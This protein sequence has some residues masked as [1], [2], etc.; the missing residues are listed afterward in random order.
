MDSRMVNP[1]RASRHVRL[2]LASC[3]PLF[4]CGCQLAY[5]LTPEQKKKVNAEFNQVGKKRVAVLVWAEQA[6]LDYDALARD[7]VGRTITYY[8]KKEL[9]EASFV[10]SREVTDLQERSGR[11]W[12]SMSNH[13][14]CEALK[15][16]LLIRVDLLEYTTRAEAARELRKGRVRGTV[17]VYSTDPRAGVDSIYQT[18]VMAT[19]PQS[20]NRQPLGL[21]D[22][23]MLRETVEQFGLDVSRKFYAYEVP[24]KRTGEARDFR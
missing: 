3:L 13:E 11:D 16:D 15:C 2:A 4:L 10:E 22:A 5:F 19:Y 1:V 24:L 20:V 8:L 6:T 21:T 7:R 18:E 12:E 17:N 14:L 23:E 9:P